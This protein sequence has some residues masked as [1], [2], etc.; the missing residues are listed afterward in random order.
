M[1]NYTRQKISF[2][3]RVGAPGAGWGGQP[4]AFP[5]NFH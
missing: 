1:S 4:L 3:N 5:Y 2:G